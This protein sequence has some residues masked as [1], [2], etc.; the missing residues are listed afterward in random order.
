MTFGNA[1]LVD[2]TATFSLPGTYTLRLTANDGALS[3]SDDVV[4]EVRQTPQVSA[5]PDRSITLGQSA[6][7]DGTL[8]SAGYP[9]A[10]T[11]RWTQ[12]SGPGTATFS[13]ATSVDTNATF[14]K[15]GNYTL[16]LTATNGALSGFDEVVVKVAKK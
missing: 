9:G 10:A 1:G 13:A 4:V 2:T 14:S 3:A 16:R 15:Q 11:V 6:S 12:V 7:L 8:I 5:G